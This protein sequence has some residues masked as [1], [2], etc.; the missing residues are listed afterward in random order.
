ML[1]RSGC[2]SFNPGRDN[3]FLVDY[4]GNGKYTRVTLTAADLG[5][6]KPKRSYFALDLSLEHR[7][8][9][10]WYGKLTYT[11]SRNK[12]NTEG[13]TKSDN[14]QTDVAATSTWDNTQ[15]M[16]GS[17]GNL[18]NDRPHQVKAFGF[19]QFSPE[20]QVGGNFL[21]E[22]GRPKNCFGN[23][24]EIGRAHV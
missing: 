22:A 23:Y 10:N 24:G 18:P 5:F 4:A 20:W 21:A 12:G 9:D 8:R 1:F 11:Y 7:L 14:A 15:L 3:T 19:Y 13:Q 2:A 16:E 17:Y 6:D